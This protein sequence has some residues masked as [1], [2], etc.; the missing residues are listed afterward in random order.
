MVARPTFEIKVGLLGAGA[1]GKTSLLSALLIRPDLL[2]DSDSSSEGGSKSIHRFRIVPSAA[3]RASYEAIPRAETGG[4]EVNDCTVGVQDPL[5]DINSDDVQ[6]I[7]EDIGGQCQGTALKQYLRQAWKNFDCL[8]FVADLNRSSYTSHD[9]DLFNLVDE[10]MSEKEIPLVIVGNKFDNPDDET[11]VKRA[12][13]AKT[14]LDALVAQAK[15]KKELS[16]CEKTNVSD[17]TEQEE[18]KEDDE[19]A[20]I[21]VDSLRELTLA[22][23]APEFVAISSRHALCYQYLSTKTKEELTDEGEMVEALLSY[24]MD[25]L[26]LMQLSD[27]KKTDMA[28]EM[29]HGQKEESLQ[30][31]MNALGPLEKLRAWLHTTVL[32]N[33]SQASILQRQQAY[34]L[35]T[36][37]PSDPLMIDRLRQMYLSPWTMD[38]GD[39]KSLVSL[40]WALY[41]ACEDNA[42]AEFNADMNV[43]A[44]E[45]PIALLASYQ[46]LLMETQWEETSVVIEAAR[47]LLSRQ[48]HIIVQHHQNSSFQ[49]WFKKRNQES[50]KRTRGQEALSWKTLSPC[51]WATIYSSILVVGSDRHFAETLGK[52]KI[53]LENLLHKSYERL[54]KVPND[55]P[56]SSCNLIMNQSPE[57]DKKSKG[58][59]SRF[60]GGN[61]RKKDKQQESSS[62]SNSTSNTTEADTL[63]PF[64]ASD[65][66][67]NLGNSLDGF[68][69]LQQMGKFV[70]KY[71]ETYACVVRVEPPVT[72]LNRAHFGHVAWRYCAMLEAAEK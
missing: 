14:I 7:F 62:H 41:H 5:F 10:H 49:E 12:E 72:P 38:G 42:L 65:G 55:H 29:L 44:L 43:S 32:E 54:Y 1:C 67:P 22:I 16:W 30:L 64:V 15:P 69:S 46:E 53:V 60:F 9:E 2:S 63:P 13:Q 56:N 36:L 35:A 25:R 61:T 71:P 50:W 70:P 26:K 23:Q 28:W 6:I 37:S 51:D 3:Q 57:S 31:R 19:R 11:L 40:F 48:L 39:P 34:H 18:K 4:V 17:K 8:I 66:C 21:G 68:Y 45:R 33:S 20:H 59:F 52:Q 58:A 47:S 27:T 24:Q